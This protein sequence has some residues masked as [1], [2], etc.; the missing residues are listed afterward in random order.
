MASIVR[1]LVEYYEHL[2]SRVDPRSKDWYLACSPLVPIVIITIYLLFVKKW[3][4][5]FMAQRAALKIERVII[6]YNA[7]QIIACSYVAWEGLR[8]WIKLRYSIVCQPVDFTVN[9]DNA[10]VANLV[11]L[12]YVIKITDLLDTVFFI[13]RKKFSHASFLHVYHHA[14]MVGV[15]YMACKFSLNGHFISLGIL[16]SFVH[17]VM[18]SYYLYTALFPGTKVSI[19]VKKSLTILQLV[20]FALLV[21]HDSLPLIHS[22]CGVEKIFCTY[23]IVQYTFMIVL[24]SDFY[25]K[26][27]SSSKKKVT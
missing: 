7:L 3:G 11:F 9:E 8:L 19:R 24:F 27:Y 13:L 20:Q 16:N 22:T 26:A 23:L 14:G 17:V 10:K 4:P 15:G 1:Y 12:Y 2:E 21:V 25:S 18:Y 6:V 5:S